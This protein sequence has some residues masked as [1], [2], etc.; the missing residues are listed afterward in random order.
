MSDDEKDIDAAERELGLAPP[1]TPIGGNS[2]EA[3][4]AAEMVWAERFDALDQAP[5]IEP[6][7]SLLDGIEAVIDTATGAPGTVTYGAESG[8]WETMLPGIE[9]RVLTV[10][11]ADGTMSYYVRMQAGA[12]LPSHGHGRAEHCVVMS[13]RLRIGTVEAGPGDFHL[14][15][16]G[17][18]HLPIEAVEP[19]TFFIH[20]AI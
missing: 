17:G 13:G 12:V 2:A 9:R 14:G 3:I 20:G 5:E 6:P 16:A 4:S 11:R 15:F 19:S 7:A 1:A 18:E 10:D 8:Y